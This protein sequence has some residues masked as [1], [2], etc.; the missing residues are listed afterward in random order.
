MFQFW[1]KAVFALV[2]FVCFIGL[3]AVFGEWYENMNRGGRLR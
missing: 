2:G 3:L 1:V